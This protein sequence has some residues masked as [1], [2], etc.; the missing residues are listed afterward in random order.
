MA[1]GANYYRK[2]AVQLLKHERELMSALQGGDETQV[3]EA[4]E[5]VRAAQIRVLKS[6]EAQLAQSEKSAAE[7]AELAEKIREWKGLGVDKIIAAYKVGVVK[8]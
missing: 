1:W 2:K 7:R 6:R 5:E 4:A 8:Q 3:L